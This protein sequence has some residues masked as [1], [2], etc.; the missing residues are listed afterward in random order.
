MIHEYEATISSLIQGIAAIIAAM[1]ALFG[2]I[3]TVLAYQV[4]QMKNRMDNLEDDFSSSISLLNAVGVW[5]TNGA[6][7]HLRP[8]IPPNL[9]EHITTWPTEVASRPIQDNQ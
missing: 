6:Q 4:L 7:P 5:L 1:L 9:I 3:I 8:K 2:V